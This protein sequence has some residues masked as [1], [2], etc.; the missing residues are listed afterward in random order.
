LRARPAHLRQRDGAAIRRLIRNQPI[1]LLACYEAGIAER[2]GVEN[3]AQVADGG[4]VRIIAVVQAGIAAMPVVGQR[5]ILGWY[6]RR[7]GPQT[8]QHGGIQPIR[9]E[10]AIRRIGRQMHQ[11]H[12]R[13]GMAGM[14]VE[15]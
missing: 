5:A 12:R 11:W 4:R 15:R 14:R 10:P 3:D 7:F 1:G 8:I 2:H 6:D 9:A 13:V